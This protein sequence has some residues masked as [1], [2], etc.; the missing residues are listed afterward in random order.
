MSAIF[1]FCLD[2]ELFAKINKRPGFYTLTETR[3]INNSR[4]KQNK[5]NPKHPF[6]DIGKYETCANFRKTLK[7]LN[8][9]IVRAHENFQFFRQ[10]TWFL[11]NNRALSKCKWWIT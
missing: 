2:L 1:L 7:I 6:G 8:S 11:G 3:F 10:I 9:V 5:K 4:F